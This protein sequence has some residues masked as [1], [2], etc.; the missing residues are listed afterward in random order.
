MPSARLARSAPLTLGQLPLPYRPGLSPGARTGLGL[1]AAPT[2]GPAHLFTCSH[3]LRHKAVFLPRVKFAE[4]T[5]P[6]GLYNVRE[7]R[8]STISGRVTVTHTGH[9]EAPWAPGWAVRAAG[10][11]PRLGPGAGSGSRVA[12]LPAR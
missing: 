4:T 2:W 6:A 10:R 9:R 12:P 8:S 11:Q 1:E 5:S 3:C 7:G